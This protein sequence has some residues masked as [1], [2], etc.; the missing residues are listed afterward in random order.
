MYSTEFL[1]IIREC[2]QTESMAKKIIGHY[3]KETVKAVRRA[4]DDITRKKEE[5]N[6]GDVRS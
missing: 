4:M 2:T 5:A 3:D 1:G 6:N